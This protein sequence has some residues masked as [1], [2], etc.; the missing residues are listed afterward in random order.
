MPPGNAPSPPHSPRSASASVPPDPVEPAVHEPSR[1]LDSA[2]PTTMVSCDRSTGA[3]I[4]K[5]TSLYVAATGACLHAGKPSC[6][7]SRRLPARQPVKAPWIGVSR[8]NTSVDG[9]MAKPRH[10][11]RRQASDATVQ[12][13]P[14]E[15][16][17]ILHRTDS[18]KSPTSR[19][20][21]LQ[22]LSP[23]PPHWRKCTG[24]PGHTQTA[25]SPSNKSTNTSPC[26]RNTTPSP[27]VHNKVLAVGA[28]HASAA[29]S[30]PPYGSATGSGT[31]TGASSPALGGR[32]Y[33]AG[34]GFDS[35]SDR[36]YTNGQ[37]RTPQQH[38]HPDN[39]QAAGSYFVEPSAPPMHAPY[40]PQMHA[41]PT[42]GSEHGY[43][44]SSDA[45]PPPGMRPWTASSRSLPLAAP[46]PHFAE[47]DGVSSSASSTV[48]VPPM[49]MHPSANAAPPS[50]AKAVAP[51]P[52]A[53]S[54]EAYRNSIKRSKDPAAQLDFAKYVLEHANGIAQNEPNAKLAKKRYQ[55]LAEEGLKWVRKLAG[56]GI[57]VHRSNIAAEAQFFLG[58]VHSRGIYGVPR[59]DGKA[60]SYYL[61]ASK[62]QHAE[63]NYRTAV[64]YE[65]GVGTRKD[66]TRA[67][68]FYRKAAVQSN[69][70]AMYKLGVI[71]IKGLLGVS[72]A[73]KEGINWLKRG[74][75]NATPECPHSL[76]ELALCHEAKDITGVIPDESY[77][78]QLYI[79]AGK[80]G[81]VPS[82]VRLGQAY[83]YGTLGCAVNAQKSVGW[84]TR[85]A[86]K[87]DPDAELALSGWYLTGA[88][89]FLPQNDVEA[90]LW[91]R[92]AADRGLAKAEYAVGYYYECG[93]GVARPDVKEAQRWY[94]KAAQKGNRRAIARLKELKQMG[95][96]AMPQSRAARPRRGKGSIF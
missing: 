93:I 47:R 1:E 90:Y 69:V 60:F 64:C 39:M 66:A 37:V 67:L 46:A 73:P 75:D 53:A 24:S 18:A 11:R 13:Q 78:R 48:G 40:Q 87:N 7:D 91:A 5:C 2:G 74:A 72:P 41:A 38:S 59:D 15:R 28:M 85:A 33:A 80:L 54:L 68:Q 89:P 35:S 86:E 52:T 30:A 95:V 16:T 17:G 58:T 9:S 27:V 84:Y 62:A 94:A 96:S 25:R 36:I 63:A 43:A 44:G 65:V 56:S 12:H 61:Q 6:F 88:E 51:T 92:R 3:R 31:S 22:P 55:M 71:L 14:S 81:Y 23:L 4:K 77:A 83:E 76:H 42:P 79:K 34:N 20:M 32:P 19:T 50:P 49:G 82:Q 57:T 8:S 29:H 70:P 26:P 21:A 10:I 45:L